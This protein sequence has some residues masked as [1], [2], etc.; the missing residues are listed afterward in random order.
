VT[1]RY[2]L[3]PIAIKL[4]ANYSRYAALVNVA[5]PIMLDL[6]DSTGETVNLAVLKSNHVLYIAKEDSN[7]PLKLSIKVG[8][9]AWPHCTALGKAL[10]AFCP[11][12]DRM[13]IFEGVRELPGMTKNSI[14]SLEELRAELDRVREEGIAYDDEENIVGIRCVSAPILSKVGEAIAAISISAPTVR[15]PKNRLKHL[16]KQVKS[17]AQEISRTLG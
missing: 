2:E 8:E 1:K 4:G 13:R 11:E 15:A 17:A 14:V 3:G 16:G 6:R 5:R 12:S 10:L 9:T 7:E